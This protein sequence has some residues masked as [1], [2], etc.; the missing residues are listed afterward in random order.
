VVGEFGPVISVSA[1]CA[2][3]GEVIVP[4]SEPEVKPVAEYAKRSV[5]KLPVAPANR[6]VPPII[7]LISVMERTPG[8]PDG[9]LDPT[10]VRKMLSPLAAIN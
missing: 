8:V 3:P 10:I 4:W 2:A 1:Q 9:A 7:V 6:P 5:L